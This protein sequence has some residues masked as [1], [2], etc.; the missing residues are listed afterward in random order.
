MRLKRFL[1][2]PALFLSN[3][4]E[5]TGCHLIGPIVIVVLF[6]GLFFKKKK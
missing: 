2:L 4:R 6:V 1:P 5:E 3:N